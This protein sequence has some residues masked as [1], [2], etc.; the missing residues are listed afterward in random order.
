MCRI[1]W[2]LIEDTV[3]PMHVSGHASD[4]ERDVDVVHLRERYLLGVSLPSSF[5]R[6]RCRAKSFALGDFANHPRAEH[7]LNQLV[8]GERLVELDCSPTY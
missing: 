3:G 7:F 2:V 4:L 8:A 6:P 1:H 5:M